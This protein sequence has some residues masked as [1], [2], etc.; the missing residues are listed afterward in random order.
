MEPQLLL[1]AII[2]LQCRGKEPR[3]IIVV[4]TLPSTTTTNLMTMC[5]SR[6]CRP[7]ANSERCT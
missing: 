4:L 1:T 5:R 2:D 6:L 7:S 3:D